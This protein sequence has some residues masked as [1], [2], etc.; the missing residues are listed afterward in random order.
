[1]DLLYQENRIKAQACKYIGKNI[2]MNVTILI[3]LHTCKKL[4]RTFKSLYTYLCARSDVFQLN[5][6]QVA[7]STAAFYAGGYEPVQFHLIRLNGAP[8]SLMFNIRSEILYWIN[9]PKYSIM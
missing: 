6:T 9:T 4:L 2:L 8:F 1:M 5:V 7:N 3:T